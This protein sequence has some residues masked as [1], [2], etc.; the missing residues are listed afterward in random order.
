MHFIGFD[1]FTRAFQDDV[2]RLTYKNT[3]IYILATLV[4]EVAVGFALA[5]LVSAKG[6]RTSVVPHH[7]LHPG[8]AADGR[9]RGAVVASCTPT[10]PA[11]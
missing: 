9:H 7:V 4:L 3:F 10:T 8:D 6:K 5:G 1:N 2:Y 11:C